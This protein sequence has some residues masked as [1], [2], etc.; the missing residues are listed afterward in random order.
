MFRPSLTALTVTVLLASAWAAP[1]GPLEGVPP[2]FEAPTPEISGECSVGPGGFS[3]CQQQRMACWASGRT[4]V[5]VVQG[6][7][8][9]GYRCHAQ[10]LEALP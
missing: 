2:R 1:W 5:A 10:S 9:V 8:T 3:A 4:P 7:R 6:A